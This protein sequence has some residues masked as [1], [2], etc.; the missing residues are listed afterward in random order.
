MAP[1]TNWDR[2]HVHGSIAEA[3]GC[4]LHADD[5]LPDLLITRAQELGIAPS[6]LR[7]WIYEELPNDQLR[8]SLLLEA[9]A[10]WA[11]RTQRVTPG[12]DPSGEAAG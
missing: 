5:P 12:A 3:T 10:R 1:P 11:R 2:G 4:V 8:Y 7:L 6:D 9:L